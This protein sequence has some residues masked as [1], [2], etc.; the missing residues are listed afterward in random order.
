MIR[1]EWFLKDT[2]NTTSE[3]SK[4]IK[5]YLKRD[6]MLPKLKE[7]ILLGNPGFIVTFPVW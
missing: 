1:A 4:L 7:K 2:M 5:K 3:L 6:T